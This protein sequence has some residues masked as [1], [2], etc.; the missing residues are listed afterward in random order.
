MDNLKQGL[1]R[2]LLVSGLC[3]MAASCTHL[4][5]LPTDPADR[6]EALGGVAMTLPPS[7][8]SDGQV[9]PGKFDHC[10]RNVHASEED[11]RQ[12]RRAWHERN[13]D[14]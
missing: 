12:A 7:V 14:R 9:T 11:V 1:T 6:C 3:V 2:T 13:K 4:P 5:A 10:M 8:G